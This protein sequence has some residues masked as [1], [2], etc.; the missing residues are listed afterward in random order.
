[1][2]FLENL[3]SNVILRAI[4]VVIARSYSDE[5]ISP[6]CYIEQVEVINFAIT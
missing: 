1:M 4:L 3:I 2:N 6:R 5:A